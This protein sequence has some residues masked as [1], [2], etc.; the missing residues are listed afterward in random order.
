MA[1]IIALFFVS[2]FLL[3]QLAAF[4]VSAA[5]DTAGAAHLKTLFTGFITNQ[6]ASAKT[7]GQELRA[8]GDV[9]VEPAGRYYAI[10]LPHLS[11][12]E[13]DGSYTDIGILA[14]NAMP[15]EK[16]GEWKMTVAVPTPIMGY[17]AEKK[18]VLRID[19][20][21]QSFTGLWNESVGNFTKLDARYEDITALQSAEGMTLKI[22]K[23]SVLY[24]LTPSITGKT[25]SGPVQYLMENISL[26]KDGDPGQSRIGKIAIDM[27]VYDYSPDEVR[28]YQDKINAMA[29]SM[30]AAPDAEISAEQAKGLYNLIFDFI[31]TVWDG[32]DSTVT[33]SDLELSRPAI[34]GSPAGKIV[35]KKAGFGFN[36]KGFRSNNV[37]LRL[38]TQYEGLSL[39]PAPAGFEEATPSRLNMEISIDKLP[40]KELVAMGRQTLQTASDQPDGNKVA[41]MQ[42]AELIPQLLTQAGTYL[43]I[44]KSF[45][46]N[47]TYNV[48]MDGQMNAN[49]KAVMGADGKARLE[50]FGL[51]Q[52]VGMLKTRLKDPALTPE[53]K[54]S[55]QGTLVTLTVLQ[56]SGQQGKNAEGQPVRSYDLELTNEG[57]IMVNGADLSAIQGLAGAASGQEKAEPKP[58]AP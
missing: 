33:I 54:Q 47:S 36:A 43:K 42:A 30:S 10:T 5:P 8:E 7:Q 13:K 49:L 52:L 14:M 11:V 21:K 28:S 50:V 6:K 48:Q 24:D 22:P 41:G 23:A 53:Q 58:P 37:A 29:E 34:P 31:S 55:L 38:T 25:W 40:Y 2:V 1:R 46:G 26:T 32:F 39:V 18:P 35:L 17:D 44:S 4:P 56:L 45:F 51:D 9:L 16:P 20:G 3:V 19:I 12:V 15:G 57:K 27:M